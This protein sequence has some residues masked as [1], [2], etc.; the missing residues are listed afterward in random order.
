VLEQPLL[1]DPGARWTYGSSTYFLGRII[2]QVTGEA[3]DRFLDSRIFG[4]LGMAETSYELPPEKADRLVALY[5]RID[6]QLAGE[7]PPES[8]RP[9]LRGDGGLLSTSQD[10]ARF[11]QLILRQGEV[12]GVR[13][14]SVAG[15]AEM[16]RDQLE[17]LTVTTQPGA[18]PATSNAFPLGAG[19]DGFGLGFQVAAGVSDGRA[20]GSLSWAGLRNT[21]FWV[22]PASGIGVVFLTQLLPFYDDSVI[23]VLRTFERTLYGRVR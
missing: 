21:H 16:S 19:R 11:V 22:D 20:P 1:H 23:A 9:N 10:Y 12:A 8:Y 7:A 15:V 6:G 17:G 13:L 5:R 3:L 4:P 14:L 2:E 18:I